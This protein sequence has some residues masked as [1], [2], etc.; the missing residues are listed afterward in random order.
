VSE[1]NEESHRLCL[2]V[3]GLSVKKPAAGCT[4]VPEFFDFITINYCS[5]CFWRYKCLSGILD[6]FSLIFAIAEKEKIK[7]V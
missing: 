5:V 2:R 6:L 4:P 1:A 3:T 7:K